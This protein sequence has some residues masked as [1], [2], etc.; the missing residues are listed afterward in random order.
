MKLDVDIIRVYK[1]N[2]NLFMYSLAYDL[3]K[4][5][6]NILDK[7]QTDRLKLST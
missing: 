5:H 6:E 3:W 4:F 1:K 7:H 2:L